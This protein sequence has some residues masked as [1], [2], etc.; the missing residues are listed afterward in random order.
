MAASSLIASGLSVSAVQVALGHA[1]PSETPD[2]YTHFWPS[3][4]EK[5]RD[6]IERASAH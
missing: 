2:V 5:T 3:D 1:T 4:A 6:A